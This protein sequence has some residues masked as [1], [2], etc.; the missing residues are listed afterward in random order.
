MARK[1][2]Q[3]CPDR[4]H[5]LVRAAR[6]GPVSRSCGRGAWRSTRNAGHSRAGR[7]CAWL[8]SSPRARLHVDGQRHA[9]RSFARHCCARGPT[10]AWTAGLRGAIRLS[11]VADFV[12]PSASPLG[13]RHPKRRRPDGGD[14][15]HVGADGDVEGAGAMRRR[16]DPPESNRGGG[17][18]PA[19]EATDARRRGRHAAQTRGTASGAHHPPGGA[20]WS[21]AAYRRKP[22]VRHRRHHTFCRHREDT[23]VIAS[24]SRARATSYH[25]NDDRMPRP[26]T[27]RY[28]TCW[29]RF[30]END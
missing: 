16:S 27:M 13:K 10:T 24:K 9:R 21:G 20:G 25:L 3:G 8:V 28:F 30:P 14:D 29:S 15:P 4:V 12:E 2:R 19:L 7:L 1:P 23:F 11:T 22:G 6:R 26:V 5:R 17:V 18:I